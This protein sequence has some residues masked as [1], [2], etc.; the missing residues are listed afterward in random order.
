[1]LD[2]PLAGAR[3]GALPSLVPGDL[4]LNATTKEVDD[5]VDLFLTPSIGLTSNAARERFAKVPIPVRH[6][7]G[8]PFMGREVG[9]RAATAQVAVVLGARSIDL[10]GFHPRAAPV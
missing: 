6:A 8:V 1:M 9:Y 5:V 3:W 4:R 7:T 2:N 10:P